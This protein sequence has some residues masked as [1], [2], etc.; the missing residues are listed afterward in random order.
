MSAIPAVTAVSDVSVPAAPPRPL[1]KSCSRPADSRP[2]RR[3]C[4]AKSGGTRRFPPASLPSTRSCAAAFRADRSPRCTAPPPRDAPASCSPSWPRPRG[5]AR[6]ARGS[7]PATGS[8][9]PP[10]PPRASASPASCGYAARGPKRPAWPSPRRPSPPSWARAS[11]P[12]SSSTSQAC[13]SARSSACPRPPGSVWSAP[14]L[15]P[16]PPS[17]CS[18]TPTCPRSPL[19]ASLA[20]RPEGPRFAGAPGPGRLLTGLSAFAEAGPYAR[21]HATFALQTI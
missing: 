11:S 6:F 8:I 7:T 10:P 15:P 5:R 18:P 14:S 9:R 2:K 4:A 13:P 12:C 19:G 3:P 17:S 16:R 20:L 21:R 1:S